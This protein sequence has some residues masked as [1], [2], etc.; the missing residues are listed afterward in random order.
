MTASIRLHPLRLMALLALVAAAALSTVATDIRAAGTS[1]AQVNGAVE[2]LSGQQTAGGGF[3]A[4]GGESD[5]GTTADVVYALVAAGVHPAAVMAED[6]ASPLD[7]LTAQAPT[8]AENPGLAGKVALALIAAGLDPRDAGGVDLISAIEDGLDPETGF[9]GF[10][11]V[12]HS[13]ALLALAA[14]EAEIDAN[15]VD[16]LLAAQIEDGSWGFTGETTSGT[17]DSNT[18][19]IVIQA[20]VAVDGD[21]DAISAGVAY[22]LSLQDAKGAIAYDASEA[23]DIIGDANS[24]A[25]AIQALIASGNDA[26]AQID[27]LTDFQ[28]ASGAFFWRSDVADDSLLA[29]AQAIPA[30]MEMALPLNPITTEQVQP[31]PENALEEALQPASHAPGCDYFEITEHNLCGSFAEFWT[32]NGGLMIFGYP[33]SEEFTDENGRTVQMFE[34]ARFELHPEHAGTPYEILLGRL[35]AEQI[36]HVSTNP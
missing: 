26:T 13:Y 21:V 4:F 8:I 29:T 23:P 30:L 25:V 3:T 24:T 1:N 32:A 14:G 19:A 31:G 34:R 5:P 10:G 12:N 33:M 28:N 35:G 16:A 6:G 15:A 27:V 22:I 36:E 17:G 7:Y 20:L 18:T 2:W 9:Y 11:A